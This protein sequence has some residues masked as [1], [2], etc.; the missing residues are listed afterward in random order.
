MKPAAYF[1]D[2]FR[3]GDNIMVICETWIWSDATYTTLVPANTNFRHYANQI[4]NAAPQ[5]KPWYGIEQEYTL[6][7]T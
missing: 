4:F 3:G 7:A 2:P 5:E 6:L 1:R